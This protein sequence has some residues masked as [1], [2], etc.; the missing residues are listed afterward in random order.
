VDESRNK[1]AYPGNQWR[2]VPI[3]STKGLHNIQ[4][5]A[6]NVVGSWAVLTSSK[7]GEVLTCN[8]LE[9]LFRVGPVV[10]GP[11]WRGLSF[12]LWCY[13]GASPTMRDTPGRVQLGAH[14]LLGGSGS[15]LYRHVISVWHLL[16][17]I[18][19]DLV[20][21]PSPSLHS[22]CASIV[23]LLLPFGM[24]LSIS[25]ICHFRT[26][27]TFCMLYVMKRRPQ[28]WQIREKSRGDGS[29]FVLLDS[30]IS[31]LAD[32]TQFGIHFK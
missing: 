25:T 23:F 7:Y 19:W 12:C 4:K 24:C 8:S 3:S 9:L 28:S 29:Y 31:M 6:I 14:G 26:S 1:Y 15:R 11:W 16:Y 30:S 21:A 20:I 13:Y 22:E 2:R 10:G 5:T 18:R 17:G 27:L 32:S